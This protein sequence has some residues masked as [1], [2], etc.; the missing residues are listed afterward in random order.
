MSIA[1][2]AFLAQAGVGVLVL[3]SILTTL[4]LRRRWGWALTM[5]PARQGTLDLVHVAVVVLAFLLVTN[6]LVALGDNIAAPAGVSEQTWMGEAG[7]PGLWPILANHGAKL[8]A[9]ALVFLMAALWLDAGLRGLGLRADRLGNDLLWAVLIYLA[10]WPVCMG[11]AH[12]IV[13]LTGEPPTHGA[14]NV[15]RMKDI[16]GWGAALIWVSAIVISPVAEEVVFRGL[17]QTVIRGYLGS[18]WPAIGIASVLFGLMHISQPQ[19]ILPLALLGA[20]MGYLY[21]RTGSLVAPILLH[22]VFNTRTMLVD[23]LLMSGRQ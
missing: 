16:P 11:L 10:V 22:V 18:A 7:K 1:E 5:T 20:A 19:Y 12:L 2:V 3:V 4:A 9:T 17:L 23:F 21:E 8:A 6:A 15:L 14:I 13:W